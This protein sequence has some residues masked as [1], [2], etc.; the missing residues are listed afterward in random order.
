MSTE[1]SLVG[2]VGG[3]KWRPNFSWEERH[4]EKRGKAGNTGAAETQ[5]RCGEPGELC[6]LTP[7]FC[8]ETL[9]MCIPHSRRP[10]PLPP[11]QPK[12]ECGRI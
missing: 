4:G 11:S 10:S 8:Q 9:Y 5:Q 3:L 7:Q 1:K 12:G 6:P 2:T